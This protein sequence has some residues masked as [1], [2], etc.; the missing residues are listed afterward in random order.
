M[1]A[2][3]LT[4]WPLKGE[5]GH[6]G[7]HSQNIQKHINIK[8]FVAR[9][10]TLCIRAVLA[11]SVK[12]AEQVFDLPR[13][14]PGLQ[15]VSKAGTGAAKVMLYVCDASARQVRDSGLSQQQHKP[16]TE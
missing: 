14:M 12:C 2:Q 10:E 13:V 4:C 1:Q 6:L 3:L 7:T 8:I 16:G 15:S 9:F 5:T 11:R